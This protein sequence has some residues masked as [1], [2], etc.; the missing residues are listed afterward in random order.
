MMTVAAVV[1][2]AAN[3]RGDVLFQSATNVLSGA[4]TSPTGLGTNTSFFSGVNF[5]LSTSAHVS[6]IGGNFGDFVTVGNNEIFGAI[7]PVAGIT[8]APV[9]ADLSSNVLATTLIT[10]P[11]AG[12]SADVFGNL[13]L[14]LSPGF[15]GV[16]FG[17]GKFGATG[18]T[19][20]VTKWDA[21]AANTGGVQTYVL[22]QSDGAFFTQVPGARY[23]VLGTVPEPASIALMTAA[24][25][26][27]LLR[28]RRHRPAAAT[29]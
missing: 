25:A 6:Q 21:V 15:Y 4:M 9:P 10:L 2:G 20:A 19:M 7:V 27:A 8:S 24:A 1:G 17:S 18:S 3:A 22:R 14:D 28:R 29:R 5:H 16:V 26:T 11:A 12:Q 13:S 23:A